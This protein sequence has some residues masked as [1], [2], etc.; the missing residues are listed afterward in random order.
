MDMSHRD[1]RITEQNR[2]YPHEENSIPEIPAWKLHTTKLYSNICTT[3]GPGFNKKLMNEELLTVGLTAGLIFGIYG[4]IM[5]TD[6][7][8]FCYFQITVPEGE[9]EALIAAESKIWR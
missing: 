8:V 3:V 4:S 5:K 9:K 7:K 6:R 2:L 1:K